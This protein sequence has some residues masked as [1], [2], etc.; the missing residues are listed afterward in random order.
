MAHPEGKY[1]DVVDVHVHPEPVPT[2]EIYGI[3]GAGNMK[4]VRVDHCSYLDP[5]RVI[6]PMHDA[7]DDSAD[8][9]RMVEEFNARYA[10]SPG[11]NGNDY[12]NELG[13]NVVPVELPEEVSRSVTRNLEK[14]QPKICEAVCATTSERVGGLCR[15]QLANGDADC[16]DP[17]NQ[18]CQH[19][20]AVLC[21]DNSKQAAFSTLDTLTEVTNDAPFAE[22][23][24]AYTDLLR[25]DVVGRMQVETG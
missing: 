22:T 17:V 4:W 14:E 15:V 10:K 16:A 12:P 20:N 18:F 11:V 13:V 21:F 7:T 19:P 3:T 2:E 25:A 5:K 1:F 8:C 6:T 23:M 9:M 24:A